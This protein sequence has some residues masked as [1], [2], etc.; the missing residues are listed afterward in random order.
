VANALAQG[1]LIEEQMAA[2]RSDFKSQA[3]VIMVLRAIASKAHFNSA[4]FLRSSRCTTSGAGRATSTQSNPFPFPEPDT[5]PNNT[6][7]QGFGF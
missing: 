3:P 5:N 4:Q 2:K 1:S 6:M 7:V